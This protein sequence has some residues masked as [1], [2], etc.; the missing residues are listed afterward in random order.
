MTQDDPRVQAPTTGAASAAAPQYGPLREAVRRCEA[1]GRG[2]WIRGGRAADGPVR[3]DGRGEVEVCDLA[4]WGELVEHAR[5]DMT[6]TIQAGMTVARLEALLAEHN[7]SLPI[8]VP[9]P[10]QTTVGGLIAAGLCGPRRHACGGVRDLLI[11]VTV[12]GSGGEIIRGGGRVVKNVAGY[13]LCRLYTGSWGWLGVI[14]EATF[15]V[16]ARP[17]AS[18]A[19]AAS[20]PDAAQAEAAVARLLA[21]RLRPA[22]VDLLNPAA[23]ARVIPSGAAGSVDPDGLRLLVGFEG[24]REDVEEQ[25]AACRD[26]L[27]PEASGPA[28][29]PAQGYRDAMQAICDLAGGG[30]AGAWVRFSVPRSQ[31][32]ALLAELTRSGPHRPVLAHAAEGV[33]HAIFDRTEAAAVHEATRRATELGGAWLIPRCEPELRTDLPPMLGPPRADWALMLRL[34]RALDPHEVFER[35]SPF[36]RALRGERAS[37][38]AG[39]ARGRVAR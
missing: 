11:G 39:S 14:V 7:Q 31:A 32:A 16:A 24:L 18:A 3:D 29:V 30:G 12:I 15:R 23:A 35:G 6:V 21:G 4:P 19:V 37:S 33:V 26:G 5:Q 27:R 38:G 8:D 17:E 22:S 13:D 2:L 34:K 1:R 36:D 10:E 25:V 9:R 28:I 20:F